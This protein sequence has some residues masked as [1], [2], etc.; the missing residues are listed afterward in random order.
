MEAAILSSEDFN[1]PAQKSCK[2]KV[3]L[4]N[5]A[6]SLAQEGDKKRITFNKIKK[7]NLKEMWNCCGTK[8]MVSR[9]KRIKQKNVQT[10]S[11]QNILDSGSKAVEC[12]NKKHFRI[13]LNKIVK[14]Y[15][16]LMIM[17]LRH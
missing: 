3:D 10:L 12:I 15:H 16:S 1:K 7:R 4:N 14:T 11:L 5:L 13:N 2:A 6:E 9:S 17:H 8:G